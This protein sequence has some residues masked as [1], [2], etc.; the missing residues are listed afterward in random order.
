MTTLVVK[1]WCDWMFFDGICMYI[2]LSWYFTHEG[3]TSKRNLWFYVALV[4]DALWYGM[5]LVRC[6]YDKSCCSH[7][8]QA[9]TVLTVQ[10]MLACRPEV[11]GGKR[12]SIT[13]SLKRFDLLTDLEPVSDSFHSTIFEHSSEPG[14]R[15]SFLPFSQA[16]ETLVPHFL[17]LN[18]M[19]CKYLNL[20]LGRGI[21]Y[22][23]LTIQYA[24]DTSRFWEPL[25]GWH[26]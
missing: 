22:D 3:R 23:H 19:R 18:E 4:P 5:Y 10:T 16:G 13:L 17:G 15:V 2:E 1:L 14:T 26:S 25:D 9:L 8:A 21:E 11:T 12:V 20:E 6:L 24:A 7:R